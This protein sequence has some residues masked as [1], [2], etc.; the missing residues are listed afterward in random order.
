MAETRNDFSKG[1]I[2]GHIIKLAVPMTL[3]QFVNLLYNIIDRIYLGR[4]GEGALDTLTGVGVCLP[5]IMVIMAFACLVGAGGATLFSIERGRQRSEEAEYILGNAFILLLFFGALLTGIGLWIKEPAL[6]LL[7]ASDTTIV[8]ANSYMTIYLLGNIFVLLSLGLNFFINA[9]GFGTIGM[10]TIIIGAVSNLVLDPIFIFGLRLG[11]KGAALATIIS[12]GAACIWTLR[13]LLG[14]RAVINLKR[15]R[16]KLKKE[17]ILNIFKLG[18]SSFIMNITNSLVQTACN[19]NLQAYGGD[20]YIGI[21]TIISSIRE[22]VHLPVTGLTGGAEPVLSFN[23][24]AQAYSRI[25]K[26]IKYVAIILITYTTLIWAIV[27]IFPDVFVRIFNGEAEL[28][29]KSIPCIRAY[30]FGFFMMAL[31]FSGQSTFNALGKYKRAVFFSLFRKV[32]LVVPLTFILPAI[33]GLGVMGVFLA[34]PISNVIGGLASFTTMMVTI[35][36]K[37]PSDQKET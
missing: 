33:G 32:I 18:S 31:Q 14:K 16:F 12:Q 25:K 24:G 3:A 28:I 37:L 10:L 20:I 8:Y 4:M 36:R 19:V 29:E 27:F 35:Y 9:Q 21:M 13:F 6:R 26:A 11:V 34:E 22:V 7:G 5:M 1:N 23:Y 17:R 15:T 2:L 30:F